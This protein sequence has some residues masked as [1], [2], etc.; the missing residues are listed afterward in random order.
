MLTRRATMGALGSCVLVGVV[1]PRREI[2]SVEPLLLADSNIP[3]LTVRQLLHEE[4]QRIAAIRLDLVR[5]WRDGLG[6]AI[7]QRGAAVAL[8]RSDMA[9]LLAGLAREVGMTSRHHLMEDGILLVEIIRRS[10]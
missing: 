4:T 10:A 2:G 5:Q 1:R 6:R 3:A 7:L 9:L 8:V